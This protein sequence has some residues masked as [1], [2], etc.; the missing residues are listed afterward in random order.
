MSNLCVGG[1]GHRIESL[2]IEEGVDPSSKVV[3]GAYKVLCTK[4]GLTLEEIR[5]PEKGTRRRR[6]KPETA[7][8]PVTGSVPEVKPQSLDD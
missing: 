3:V 1:E 6:S 4:C 7:I 5:A 2:R 8:A